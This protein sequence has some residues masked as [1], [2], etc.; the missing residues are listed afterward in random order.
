MC[1][2]AASAHAQSFTAACNPTVI[3]FEPLFQEVFAEAGL[4]LAMEGQPQARLFASL[5]D[6]EVQAGLMLSDAAISDLPGVIKIPYPLGYTEIVAVCADP[7]I[8]IS[9]ASD[10]PAFS[11]GIVRGNKI[12]EILTSGMKL[13]AT[14]SSDSLFRMLAA[15]RFQVAIATKQV[16]PGLAKAAGMDRFYIQEPPLAS[17][18]LFLVLTE[19]GAP[20]KNRLSPVIKR[21]VESGA[22]DRKANAILAEQA[23]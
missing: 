9:S 15:G 1:L 21:W 6:N 12:H 3:A 19:S 10:L 5:L 14:E 8:R 4:Q 13:T 23:K 20:F 11:I 7:S 17:I 16:V 2:S 18:P 22:W